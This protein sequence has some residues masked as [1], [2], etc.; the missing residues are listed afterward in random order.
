MFGKRS[1]ALV[2][3]RE[4]KCPACQGKGRIGVGQDVKQLLSFLPNTGETVSV[5]TEIIAR[6]GQGICLAC[7]GRGYH[8]VPAAEE[9]L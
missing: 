8:V 9:R 2:A 5:D 4:R 6:L 3:G 7:R 1:C